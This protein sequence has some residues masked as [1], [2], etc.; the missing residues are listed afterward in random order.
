MSGKDSFPIEELKVV[1]DEHGKKKRKRRNLEK[2][3]PLI[4]EECYVKHKGV[5]RI[6][7]MF[8]IE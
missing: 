1:Q 4:F 7:N 6:A 5:N 2:Y 8:E 3:A